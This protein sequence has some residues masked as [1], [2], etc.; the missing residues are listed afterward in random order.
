MTHQNTSAA[1][2][3]NF[4]ETDN[5][6]NEEVDNQIVDPVNS[7]G[8]CKMLYAK[9]GHMKKVLYVFCIGL[10]DD[11]KNPIFD[12]ESE[13]WTGCPLAKLKIKNV[14]Y[15]GEIKRRALL[16]S[17]QPVPRPSNWKRGQILEWLQQH[18]VTGSA[19]VEFLK[20]EVSRIYDLWRNSVAERE[21]V[22]QTS[23][24]KHWRG[25]VPYLRLIF[26]LIEDHVK[27]LYLA[28]SDRRN[29]RQ[30]DARNSDIR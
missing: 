13:Q 23:G 5:P 14:D 10:L 4:D 26:C 3:S 7:A 8:V 2:Y 27:V 19:D 18:P 20:R 25:P 29:R 9:D 17:I 15:V 21:A 1:C 6:T 11:D 22:Q 24:S 12:I 28:R 30:I 16:Y